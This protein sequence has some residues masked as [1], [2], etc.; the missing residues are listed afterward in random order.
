[1]SVTADPMRPAPTGETPVSAPHGIPSQNDSRATVV[2]SA[3]FTHHSL[4]DAEET[5]Q[6]IDEVKACR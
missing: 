6:V 5:R 3:G 4:I 1:M 2:H